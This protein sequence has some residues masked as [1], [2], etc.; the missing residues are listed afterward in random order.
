[1][2]EY[3]AV[4]DLVVQGWSVRQTCSTK[5][6]L[7]SQRVTLQRFRGT[8]MIPALTHALPDTHYAA[9]ISVF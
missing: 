9:T 6:A 4:M 1:M 5:Y 3:R 8:W 2:T 7:R